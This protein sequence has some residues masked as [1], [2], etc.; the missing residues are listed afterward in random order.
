MCGR[1]EYIVTD[2]KKLESRYGAT[3]IE[4]YTEQGFHYP[5]YNIPPTTHT[6]LLTS[7]NSDEILIGHWGFLPSWAADGRKAKEVINARAESVLEKPYFKSAIMK[8][9]CLIPVTGYF[10]WKR[11]G[12][13][14]TPYRFHMDG[15][16]FSLA[17]V[18]TTIKDE[19]GF[20][21]PHY[22]IITTEANKLMSPVHNR[23]PVLIEKEDES[24]WID[25]G[26]TPME[27]GKFFKKREYEGLE[28]YQIS[29]LVN[30]PKNDSPEILQP[31]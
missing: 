9:R 21:L 13:T 20:E 11:D 5:K 7:E 3:L 23:M 14:K 1:I 18:Y 29:T 17:G 2:K 31:A 15:E 8:R 12:K 10:E 24:E 27:I 6:P 19:D 28:K 16:I 30:S 25:E 22:A 26:L 4:G